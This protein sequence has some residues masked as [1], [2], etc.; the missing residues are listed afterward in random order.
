MVTAINDYEAVYERLRGRMVATVR[1]RGVHA[2]DVEDVVHDAL[3]KLLNESIGPGAPPL[4]IRGYTALHDK[5]VEHFRRE[6]RRSSRTTSLQL[7]DAD[8]VERERPELASHDAALRLF[9]LRE[10][11]GA[12]AGQD[13]AR[14]ALLS[15]CGATEKD[16]A[17]LL[18]WPPARAAAA[19]VQLGR[20]KAQIVH[21][22]LDML[23]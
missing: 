12:I 16:I 13:A 14:F 5:Q 2:N 17:V 18:G 23:S 20:K 10:T 15:S 22:T 21:A 4:E 11:I 1:K 8:G 3:E 19:R 6:D 7:P 9:E